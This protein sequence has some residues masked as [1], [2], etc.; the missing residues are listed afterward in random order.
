M[1]K[2]HRFNLTVATENGMTDDEAHRCLRS[3]LKMA[4]RSYGIVCT[5]A[6]Q[7]TASALE[8]VND[9]APQQAKGAIDDN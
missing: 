9:V 3:F 2:R 8:G 5:S 7:L 4:I 6:V 1:S